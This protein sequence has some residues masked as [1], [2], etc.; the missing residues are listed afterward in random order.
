M[1]DESPLQGARRFGVYELLEKIGYGGMSKVYKARDTRT[2]DIV[3]LKIAS[4]QVIDD[5]QL[6][7]RF[8]LE[9]AVAHALGHP[10][11][12]KVLDNGKQ[13][14]LPYLVMEFIDGPSLAEHLVNH[15]R[16]SEHGALAIVVPIA[17]ALAYLHAKHILHR[18]VKPA[19]I[20]LTS[21]GE[22]KL[23]DLGLVKNLGSVSRLT[24]SNFGLGT[25]QFAAPEQFDDARSVDERC[26]VYSLAATMYLML[27]GEYPFGK[28][29]TLNVLERK[30]HNK[31]EAPISKVP[32]LRPSVDGAIRLALNADRASRPASINEFVALLTGEKKLRSAADVPGTVLAPHAKVTDA[33]KTAQERRG[34]TRYAIELEAACRAVINAVGQRWPATIT[35]L[36]TT[37]LC[38]SA[39]RRFETGSVLEIT[40]ALNAD[41][42]QI[43]QLARVRWAKS[44]EAKSW[45]L[46]CEF[47]KAI[48][49]DDLSTI[50]AATMDKT[51]ML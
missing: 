30:L 33:K 37:G 34:G 20:L 38:L 13:D 39:T 9:Y 19:N 44:T 11:L 43:N 2:Q 5:R 42:T 21:A 51:R 23:A 18:D 17:D 45:L 27:T 3:A 41:D 15:Q 40:F 28:G 26:D 47:I 35:D 49:E 10:N 14:Q 25:M 1:P 6:S 7:R 29:A 4:R 8:E 12:V 50:F 24:R 48:T 46:G 22:A 16:L 31:F 32:Q 36:S